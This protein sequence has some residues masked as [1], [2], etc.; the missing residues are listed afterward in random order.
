V[1][2]LTD[3]SIPRLAT[4]CRWGGTTEAPVVLFPEG[5]IKVEGTG[6]AILELCAGQLS[7]AEIVGKL[8]QQFILA[9]PGK[10]RADL[11]SF[12]E[13]LHDKRIIDY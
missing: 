9:P 10:V 11:I 13:Q 12:I 3:A 1:A 4:G 6:R 8:E 7:L 2:E 5:A